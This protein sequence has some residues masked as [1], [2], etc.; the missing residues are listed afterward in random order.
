MEEQ[1]QLVRRSNSCS[2]PYLALLRYLAPVALTLI[3]IDIGEQVKL[4]FP[5][6][7]ESMAVAHPSYFK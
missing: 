1:S 4:Y 2:G 5:P 7:M 3:A 6:S